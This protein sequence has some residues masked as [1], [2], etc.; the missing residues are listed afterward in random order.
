[1]SQEAPKSTGLA[2]ASLVL[3]IIAIAFW[4]LAYIPFL[5]WLDVIAWPVAIVG[6]ILGIIAVVKKQGAKGLVGLILNAFF[7]FW[8][9][10]VVAMILA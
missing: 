1:M 4:I 7:I 5:F 9:V 6:L 10:V 8:K 2:T 3:G